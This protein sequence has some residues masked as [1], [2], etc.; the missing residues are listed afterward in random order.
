MTKIDTELRA[1]ALQFW[2]TEGKPIIHLGPSE[3]CFDLALLLSH[4]TVKSSHLVA[5]LSWM[6][7]ILRRGNGQ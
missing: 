7:S 6:D 5:V 3:N 2:E 1:K 4:S